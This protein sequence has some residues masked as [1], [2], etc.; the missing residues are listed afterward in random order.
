[1]ITLNTLLWAPNLQEGGSSILCFLDHLAMKACATQGMPGR[2]SDFFGGYFKWVWWNVQLIYIHTWQDLGH[3][4]DSPVGLR[5]EALLL[6]P[7]NHEDVLGEGVYTTLKMTIGNLEGFY[8]LNRKPDPWWRK[9]G[10]E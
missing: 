1:M 3:H 10:F 8:S 5:K 2:L 6:A 7:W 4:L 9:G